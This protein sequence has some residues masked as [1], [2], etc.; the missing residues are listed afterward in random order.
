MKKIILL[1]ALL[2]SLTNIWANDNS[3]F[4]DSLCNLTLTQIQGGMCL[5]ATPEGTAPF[6]L[7]WDNGQTGEVAC[8]NNPAGGVLCVTMTDATGCS[9]TACGIVG[10]NMNCGVTIE[11]DTIANTGTV[12]LTAVPTGTAP[13]TYNWTTNET[14]QTIT[15]FGPG[16]YCVVITDANGCVATSCIEIEDNSN[17]NC[18]VE[19]GLTPIGGL[20][21]IAEG[22]A[23]FSYLWNTGETTEFIQPT[24]SGNYCVTIADANGC[25]SEDCFYYDLGGNDTLCFVT[26][27]QVPGTTCLEA[28]GTGV[29]PLEFIWSATGTTGPTLCVNAPG[30]YCVT[31]ID[32]SGCASTA[33]GTIVD[34]N[35]DSCSVVII[36][37]T[38]SGA[39]AANASGV[40][41]FTYQWNTG[42]P[43]PSIFPTTNGEYCV[44]VTDAN[45]CV[46]VDCYFYNGNPND[47]T[48]YVTLVE[49]QGGFCLEAIASGT[50]P[51]SYLWNTGET[52]SLLCA[53]N[54]AGGVYCVTV[55]DANGCVVVACGILGGG[56]QDSCSV[57]IDI[58]AA[59]QLGAIASG[60]APFTYQW[61]TGELTQTI[62]PN[63]SG[64]YCVT[65]TDATG[66]EAFACHTSFSGGDIHG[67]V[68]INDSAEY[69]IGATVY[70]IQY[71][72]VEGTLT[73]IDQTSTANQTGLFSFEDVEPGE[74]LLKA[75]L[76]PNSAH[77]AENLPTYYDAVLWWNEATS[78]S[79][80]V[81]NPNEFFVINMVP[82]NNPGGPG[83]IGGLVS[84]GAN[85]TGG[86]D[87]RGEGDPMPGVSIL[88]LDMDDNPVIHTITNDEGE[89]AFD[90]LAY[91]TY[92]VFIEIPGINQVWKVVTISAETPSVSG[93]DFIVDEDSAS[94][95]SIENILETESLEAFPNPVSDNFYLR[96]NSRK[97]AEIFI[98]LTD[99][100][101][102]IIQSERIDLFEG[103]NTHQ[104]EMKQ[105][106]AGIYI[107]NII[108]GKDSVSRKVVKK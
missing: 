108:N 29:A 9:I 10:N 39:L 66:C 51:F 78:I 68:A 57:F 50:A 22:S 48:C 107:V 41:P 12:T 45:G 34:P 36:G 82:G 54:P 72:P 47:T 1:T 92:K 88:L 56:G 106:P 61:N 105:L 60:Q 58:T 84:E 96:W 98:S 42:E 77:Y 2:F 55:T 17:P 100:N 13:F 19:V 79:V 93:I 103:T 40:A 7:V 70:L 87:H 63:N 67:F 33:C 95:V 46:A 4:V 49:V 65:I 30:T 83:F 23:P 86:A 85:F 35:Q 14:T 75:A 91:G 76:T 21:A 24:S 71:D 16:E 99:I 8:S 31:M 89:Y 94:T 43:T 6:T 18:S 5:Q 52:S 53:N 15:V 27:Q 3:T 90:D 20:V 69:A 81:S 59:G 25:T 37:N 28:T 104:L 26:V 102:R 62:S 97:D 64:T 74:Y 80:P 11:Q 44:T 101:G 32:A 38:G 73:E